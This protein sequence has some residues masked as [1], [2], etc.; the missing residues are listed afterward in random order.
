MGDVV[1]SPAEEK[2]RNPENDVHH[3][4]ATIPPNDDYED[5]DGDD[6]QEDDDLAYAVPMLMAEVDDNTAYA[7]RQNSEHE[8]QNGLAVVSHKHENA[9]DVY[10]EKAHEERVTTDIN[11]H[12][13]HFFF[14]FSYGQLVNSN[15]HFLTQL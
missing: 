3:A 6:Y 13:P 7:K 12:V 15:E 8:V 2:G 1:K 4:F 14:S 9:E 11:Y 5:A 10:C